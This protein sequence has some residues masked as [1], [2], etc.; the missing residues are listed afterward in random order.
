MPN[1]RTLFT[2]MTPKGRLMVGG[3]GGEVAAEEFIDAL[4]TVHR[5]GLTAIGAPREVSG[6]LVP[7]GPLEASGGIGAHALTNGMTIHDESPERV[8]PRPGAV[9]GA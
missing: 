6:H 5:R 8:R 4:P 2:N 3:S 1:V 9:A 7:L